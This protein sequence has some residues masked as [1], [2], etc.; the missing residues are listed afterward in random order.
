M[1]NRHLLPLL[2]LVA[3]SAAAAAQTVHLS[4]MTPGYSYF[5][6][7]GATWAAH[8]SDARE[9]AS[10]AN[11]MQAEEERN[12]GKGST[13]IVGA[14]IENWI[15]GA[16][17][18][19]IVAAALEN[20][21]VVRGWRVVS[22]DDPTGSK[23]ASLPPDELRRVLT[24][25]IG[26]A[27]PTGWVSRWWNNDAARA[28]SSRFALR[29]PAGGKPLSLRAIAN[30]P[31]TAP[32]VVAPSAGDGLIE[33]SWKDLRRTVEPRDWDSVP[34]DRALVVVKM[35]GVGPTTG[36]TLLFAHVGPPRIGFLTFQHGLSGNRQQGR[37]YAFSVQPGM[38]RLAAI[39][40]LNLCLGAPAFEVRAGEVVYAGS[41]D[42]S[43]ED[44]GPDLSLAEPRAFLAGH[45][46]AQRLRPAAYR[47]GFVERCAGT[48]SIYA[49]EVPGAPFEPTYRGGSRAQ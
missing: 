11:Q 5:N 21:M 49:L 16:A 37:F 4:R 10:V 20:C 24:D 38:W 23:W 12:R 43:A 31:N 18:K 39:H 36:V 13:G 3:T 47:N 25:Q 29:P 7:P 45:A 33:Q 34:G 19:G 42:L 14:L 35:K 32:P 27:K 8:D 15:V 2:P 22:V 26:A 48:G 46:A 6:R 1:K 40:A 28:S 30:V 41:F 9:C 44:I 17:H